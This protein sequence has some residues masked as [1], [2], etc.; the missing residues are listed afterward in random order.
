MS[1]A[2]NELND[3]EISNSKALIDLCINHDEFVSKNVLRVYNEMKK[4]IKNS[5]NKVVY[6][7]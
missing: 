4:Q 6:I 1:L 5:T 3:I 2:K 7:I